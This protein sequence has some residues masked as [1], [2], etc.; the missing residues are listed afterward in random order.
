V[1]GAGVFGAVDAV[2]EAHDALVVGKLLPDVRVGAGR[3]ADLGGH[4]LD[5]LGGAAVQRAFERADGGDDGGV[6]VRERGGGDAG[7]KGRG[8]GAMLS[9]EQE[10]EVH[11]VDGFLA[12]LLAFEHVE[13]VG[14]VRKRG[15][16]RHWLEAAADA[17]VGGDDGGDLGGEAL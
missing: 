17:V 15:Q 6:H 12:R 13:E 14:G 5:R 11:G 4:L 2:A 8:V 1:A 9:V 10:V 7:R 16:W 3:I